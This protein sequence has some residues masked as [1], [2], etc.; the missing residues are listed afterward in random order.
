MN[1]TL[2]ASV[3]YVSLPDVETYTASSL[4]P[5]PAEEGLTAFPQIDVTATIRMLNSGR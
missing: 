1:A 4:Q 3:P 5:A 2:G